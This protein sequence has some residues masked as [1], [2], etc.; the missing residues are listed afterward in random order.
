MTAAL[1]LT[2]S[3]AFSAASRPLSAASAT[4]ERHASLC[5]RQLRLTDFRSYERLR[6][7]LTAQPVVLAGPNGA[8]K[9]NLLEAVSLLA[10][11]RGLRRAKLDE[12]ARRAPGQ[13][14]GQGAASWGVA[15]TLD[16]ASGPL[17]IGTGLEPAASR[18]A[19][20]IDGSPATSQTALAEHVEIGRASCRERV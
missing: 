7:E 11:G 12:F 6:L 18:R 10:P 1:A 5:V 2:P 3:L 8:G 16:C 14:P 13:A 4:V 19:V 17:A 15:A 20:R 9:T